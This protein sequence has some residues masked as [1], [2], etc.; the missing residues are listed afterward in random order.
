MSI[1][2]EKIKQRLNDLKEKIK[3]A[4]NRQGKNNKNVELVAVSKTHN[5]AEVEMV[6]KT[7]QRVFGENRVQEAYSKWPSLK[8]KYDDVKL[9]LIGP[10]QTNKVKDAVALFDVIETLDREKLAKKLQF[11][12]KK[13]NKSLEIFVQVNIGNEPQKAGIDPQEAVQFVKKCK[14]EYGLNIVALMAI[15]PL[16]LPAGPYFAQL[17]QLAYEAGVE[18]LSMGMSKDFEEAIY[19]GAAYVRVGT[20]IFGS[21]GEYNK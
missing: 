3:K 4:Q 16:D 18:N 10:L 20:A 2:E 9:H 11:E 6:I 5:E 15:P 12:M 21:R 1:S 19:M 8:E 17:R 14:N 7:G 13:A